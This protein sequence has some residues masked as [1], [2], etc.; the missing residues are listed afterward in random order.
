M[1]SGSLLTKVD[2]AFGELTKLGLVE[3]SPY[4]VFG[5]QATGCSPIATAFENGW[6]TVKPVKPDTIAKSLA[7]GNPADGPYALDVVR[8]TG[9]AMGHVSD[10]EVIEG[11]SLL[12]ETEGVFAETAGGV[13]VATLRQLLRDGKVDPDAETVLY[14]TGDGLKTIEATALTSVPTVTIDPSY[15]A[16]VKSGAAG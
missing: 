15:S 8:R 9:G 12:A 5:A 7:I 14:N 2:K 10:A 6:D 4:K 1:A 11:I 16:F 3:A 13:T